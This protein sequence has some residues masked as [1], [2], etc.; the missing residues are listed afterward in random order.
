VRSPEQLEVAPGAGVVTSVIIE[1]IELMQKSSGEGLSDA[2]PG[3]FCVYT[4]FR[5]HQ[6]FTRKNGQDAA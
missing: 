5:L 3:F 1:P 4:N 2:T 6:N